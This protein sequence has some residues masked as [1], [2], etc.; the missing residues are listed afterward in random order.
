M[1]SPVTIPSWTPPA[2]N[3]S[4]LLSARLAEQGHAPYLTFYDDATG[5]RTELSYATFENWVAK[6][7][8]LL[9]EE[10]DVERGARV[11]TVLGN[12]WTTVVVTFACW[13][14]G[15]CVVP[16]EA[17]AP[18]AEARTI[19]ETSG[20]VTAFVR[21]D[22]VTELDTLTRDTGLRRLVVVG[23]GPGARD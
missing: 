3:L 19:V 16:C 21:E 2:R 9:V 17:D 20:A 8:N 14:V 18:V 12:H 23:Q 11:A 13:K 6:T 15:A 4:A 7:A 5:E 10:L 22:L 1:T